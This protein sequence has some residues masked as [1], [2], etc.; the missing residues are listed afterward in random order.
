MDGEGVDKIPTRRCG[1]GVG[2]RRLDIKQSPAGHPASRYAGGR[3]Q[4]AQIAGSAWLDMCQVCIRPPVAPNGG[5]RAILGSA[6]GVWGLF[7]IPCFVCSVLLNW[8]VRGSGSRHVRQRGRRQCSP[9]PGAGTTAVVQVGKSPEL[10]PFWTTARFSRNSTQGGF[11]TAALKP[12]DWTVVGGFQVKYSSYFILSPPLDD[13]P[14]LAVYPYVD[15]PTSPGE[16]MSFGQMEQH[17]G[18][19]FP[20]SVICKRR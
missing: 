7:S 5:N 19:Y 18:D 2:P 9:S 16:I 4:E 12:I 13:R 10:G 3:K 14:L 1:I 15:L 11:A 6:E 8:P 17:R 20:Y